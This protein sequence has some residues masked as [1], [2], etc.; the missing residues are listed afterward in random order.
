MQNDRNEELISLKDDKSEKLEIV[1]S[2]NEEQSEQIQ[3]SDL[4]SLIYKVDDRPSL[5]LCFILGLQ[6]FL[7]R[8]ISKLN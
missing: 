2:N 3:K 8:F 4:P 5:P 7:V 6:H 1:D